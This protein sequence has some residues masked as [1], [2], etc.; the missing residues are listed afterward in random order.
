MPA[1]IPSPGPREGS[2]SSSGGRGG[3]RGWLPVAIGGGLFLTAFDAFLLQ[4]KRA[5]FTGGFLSVDNAAHPADAAAFLLSSFATDVAVVGV[6]AAVVLWLT[7]RFRLTAPARLLI[8]LVAAVAPF[9]ILDFLNYQLLQYLGDTFDLSL[10]FD[11][12]GRSPKELLAVAAKHLVIPGA[13][14]LGAIAALGVTFRLLNRSGRGGRT[15]SRMPLSGVALALLL[16][17]V[18]VV[19]TTALRIADDVIDNGLRRKPTGQLMSWLVDA[20]S[21]VDRD[22]YGIGGQMADPAPFDAHIYPY[23]LDVP[24]DGV[25]QDGVGGDLPASGMP[26]REGPAV[27]PVFRQHP[28]IVM[29]ML[30]SFR[31]DLLGSAVGGVP[32]TPVLDGIAKRG[33]SV[34][35]AYSP[36]GYTVQ[37]RFHTL[38]G[39]LLNLRGGR[40]LVDDFKANGYQVAYFS[41]QDESF[42]GQAMSIGFDRADVSYDARQD[43][44]LRNSSF[45]TAG[46]LVVPL[47]VLEKRVDSFLQSRSTDRPL[48]LYLNFQDTHFPYYHPGLASIVPGRVLDESAIT[49]ANRDAVH[50]MYANA[51]ANVDRAIGSM[52]DRVRTAV[53][54]EPAIIVLSDHGE[55]LFDEGF[56]GHGYALNDVQTRIPLVAAGLP[57]VIKEPFGEADLRDAVGDALGGESLE[58]RP[59][60]VAAPGKLVFQYLGSIDRPRQI[61]FVGAPE[62]G[63]A[64]AGAG[65]RIIYDFRNG[66]A[67]AADGTWRAPD[68]LDPP[69]RA[70]FLQLIRYW[71]QMMLARAAARKPAS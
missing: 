19:T 47:S 11:L 26:Y 16:F 59:T 14:A 48:F 17:V 23:A 1:P 12:T 45:T 25:D 58:A 30:E 55:S 6:V 4:E 2:E 61:A 56:L 40:T 44:K 50:A 53:G 70:R 60:V 64:A 62:S 21:D 20:T 46:S 13:I 65:A 15:A 33:L 8:V 49:P 71:E 67:L 37:S 39:S 38:S 27:S 36:N 5:F 9:V 66:R 51:A 35:L 54:A 31:A 63:G 41:A 69:D 3:V 29:V 7:G 18:V 57:L 24:G 22:G 52:L 10:M 32:V 34:P 42:G 68:R 28:P 43:R